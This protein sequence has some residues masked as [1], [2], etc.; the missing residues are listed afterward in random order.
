MEHEDNLTD[1][2]TNLILWD[3]PKEQYDDVVLA[4]SF[5]EEDHPIDRLFDERVGNLYPKDQMITTVR[6]FNVGDMAIQAVAAA[7][8][9]VSVFS[10]FT[11]RLE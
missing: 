7:L 1:G 3:V 8:L 11:L 9:F 2:P 10:R 5:L 6:E 4:L